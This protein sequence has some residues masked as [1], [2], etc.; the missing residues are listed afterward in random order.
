M[1]CLGSMLR[2]FFPS[3]GSEVMI[4]GPQR[5]LHHHRVA[6]CLPRNQAFFYPPSDVP[7][8]RDMAGPLDRHRLKDD[9]TL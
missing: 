9:E 8:C 4:S 6:A 3:D 7:G 1:E 2:G 5:V